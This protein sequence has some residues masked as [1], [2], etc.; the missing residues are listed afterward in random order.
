MKI[1]IIGGGSAYTP[2]LAEGL[3]AIHKEVPFTEVSLMDIDGPKLKI[4]GD[5]VH[6]IITDYNPNIKVTLTED[7]VEAINGSEFI[8]CQI[9]VGG[10]KGRVIDEKIPLKYNCIGQETVGAGGFAMALRSIPVMMDIAKDIENYAPTAWLINYANPSG[11]VAQAL[12]KHS[13]INAISICDVPIGIQHFIAKALG[14]PRE[15]VSLDY[16]G[17]NHLGWFRKVIVDGQ[18]ITPKLKQMIKGV[19]VGKMLSIDDE[20]T[21]E[22]TEMAMKIFSKLG[23]IPSPYIQYYYLQRESLEKQL[24]SPKTRGEVVQ[25]IE[26]ELLTHFGEVVKSGEEKLW[27]ARGGQWH[28]E[29]MV[30]MLSTIHNDKK[31]EYII[32]VINNGSVPGMGQNDCVEIPCILDKNGIT[33]KMVEKPDHD[34]LGLMQLVAAY[35]NLTVE[36]ALEGSYD[37]ALRA[38]NLNPLIP[39]LDLAEKILN[40]YIKSHGDYIKLS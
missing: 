25:E 28:A 31:E 21:I 27:K 35:E 18:D 16:V 30:R 20:K 1:S 23:V 17:L 26:K 19:N 29:L 34:I 13:I 37:K 4:V 22:E 32:N 39:S 2:G 3:V 8:L 40:D 11:M 10:L 5:V 12:A 33:P 6:K 9:R 15:M 7:R 24:A 36:A 14:L 38:L